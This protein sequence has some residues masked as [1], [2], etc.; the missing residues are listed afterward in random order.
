MRLADI[1]IALRE[2]RDFSVLEHA[3]LHRASLEDGMGIV[4]G[5]DRVRD[6]IIATRAD[7][8]DGPVRIV[9]D[10]GDMIVF[11]TAQ[12]W[13]GHRW[14]AREGDRIKALTSIDDGTARCRA[15]GADPV[16]TARHLGESH[17]LHAPLGEL[18][19]GIGQMATPETPD[20]PPHFPDAA[21][22]QATA[23][24]RLW[25]ARAL[26]RIAAPWHGPQ[27]ADGDGVGFV[28]GLIRAL[29][30]AVLL[31]ERGLVTGDGTVALLWR[32]IGHH[33]GDCLWANASGTRIRAIGSSVFPPKGGEE[34]MIDMLHVQATAFRPAIDYTC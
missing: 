13:R 29:P 20:L 26:D 7:E 24:H 11:E 8:T 3:C 6:A 27:D 2:R 21:V 18:R 31:I 16:A 15:I 19:P 10:L 5:R 4:R 33:L 9:H 1:E 23:L 28:L 22:P 32:L 34:M 25:N 12:G 30:D 14:A 17:P